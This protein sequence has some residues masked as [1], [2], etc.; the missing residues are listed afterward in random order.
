M[1][2]WFY[3]PIFMKSFARRS[4]TGATRCFHHGV[5]S[6]QEDGE[7][8]AVGVEV[9][10]LERH[11]GK[12]GGGHRRGCPGWPGRVVHSAPGAGRG[13]IS[14][15]P[16]VGQRHEGPHA[17]RPPE[18]GPDTERGHSHGTQDGCQL[19]DAHPPGRGAKANASTRS[20]AEESG[21]DRQTAGTSE[22]HDEM[23]PIPAKVRFHNL[24]HTLASLLLSKGHILMA[25]RQSLVY[26]NTTTSL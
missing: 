5:R 22:Q 4:T 18:S 10:R 26:A 8:H 16:V 15:A 6:R 23:Q 11:P 1:F 17:D 20:A 7:S 2:S 12:G 13:G 9:P 25:V 21:Q 24:R 14:D 3:S 19:A